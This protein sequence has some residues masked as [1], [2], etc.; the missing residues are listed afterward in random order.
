MEKANVQSI[1]IAQLFSTFHI[2]RHHIR[3]SSSFRNAGIALCL[4]NA[5]F[6]VL[7]VDIEQYRCFLHQFEVPSTRA[8]KIATII[9]VRW[10]RATEQMFQFG[11][12][13][14]IL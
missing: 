12:K 11:F 10:A 1:H 7:H 5:G 2:G 3:A 8:K 13:S 6:P 14:S 4:D 9:L